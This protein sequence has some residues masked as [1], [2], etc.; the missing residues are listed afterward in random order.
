MADKTRNIRGELS[1]REIF[2]AVNDAILVH[3]AKT[4][5]IL[6]ANPAAEQLYGYSRAELLEMDIGEFSTNQPAYSQ[7]RAIEQ[8]DRAVQEGNNRFEWMIE[9]KDGTERT[10]DVKLTRETVQEGNLLLAVV[11]DVTERREA[12]RTTRQLREAVESSMDGVAVLDN[13]GE[14]VYVNGAHAE[15][16][17]FD[18]PDKLIGKSWR[19]MYTDEEI[20]RLEREAMSTIAA[21]GE[22]R[23]EATG[24]RVD[25]EHFPQEVSLTA[26]DSGGLICVVRDVT[27]R[28]EMTERVRKTRRELQ[29]V[30]DNTPAAVYKKDS[31]GRYQY[32]NGYYER[33]FDRPA[34]ELIGRLPVEIHGE[35]MAEMIT[36]H[37][38]YVIENGKATTTEETIEID[39]S[40]R[41]FLTSRIPLFDD[42][43]LDFLYGIAV[44]ITELKARERTLH[45]LNETATALVGARNRAEVAQLAV[46]T[47]EDAFSLPLAGVWEY[48][49]EAEALVPVAETD[50]SRD[51]VGEAPTFEEG[52]SLAWEAFKTSQP[53]F[54]EDVSGESDMFNPET[55][56]RSEMVLPL[57]EYGVLLCASTN[58]QTFDDYEREFGATLAAT[59]QTALTRIERERELRRREQV[60]H[61][62]TEVATSLI[63]AE[64]DEETA[65]IAVETAQDVLNLPLAGIWRHESDEDVLAPFVTSSGAEEIFDKLPTFKEGRGLSWR[66]FT[67]GRPEV[68]RD[69]TDEDEVYDPETPL[70]SEILLPLGEHG[71]FLCGT[72]ER[73]RFDEYALEFA[74]ILSTM[75]ESALTSADRERELRE[76]REFTDQL[77]STLPDLFYVFDTTSGTFVRWNDRLTEL[78]GYSDTEV[79]TTSVTEFVAEAD[80]ATLLDG[81]ESILNG[82]PTT[83]AIHIV[84]SDGRE[85][86]H[87]LTG[88]PVRDPDG[89]IIGVCGIGRDISDRLAY[90]RE[91][92]RKNAR[93][94]EFAS[95]VAHDIRNPLT[96]ATGY[97]ELAQEVG[98]GRY[99]EEVERG[100]ART[101]EI[102]E[103]LLT[104]AR[105]GEGIGER[106]SIELESLARKAW[107]NVR[108]SRAR[109]LIEDEVE[110]EGDRLRLTQLF[111]NLFRNAIEHAGEDVTIC[112][113]AL[114][115]GFY[116]EDNGSGIPEEHRAEL[117]VTRESDGKN[118]RFGLAI[119]SDIVEAHGWEIAVT[120]G[121]NGGA[122]FEIETQ[123]QVQL[124]TDPIESGRQR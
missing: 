5:T 43:E 54:V 85:V 96:V 111:E 29:A 39:G 93:L 115:E 120:N 23:G 66:V 81:L 19:A 99:L 50:H 97:L 84:A 109:L 82:E 26:L 36:A 76:Q 33:L 34:S 20:D 18:D 16:Y 73:R 77:I 98:D 123:S 17:G 92:E 114:T 90:E 94:E 8:I 100:L 79:E 9:R 63:D 69:V 60:L 86:P 112:F 12:E 53:R 2:H 101:A 51:I 38:Q 70:R 3:D 72:V 46:D 22:W 121:D 118:A 122:R 74:S 62:L 28:T 1:Y 71:V 108:T 55:S 106:E 27:E 25:G 110:V 52:T 83:I 58:A 78:T 91:L 104:L 21:E 61:S 89:E 56:I 4:G 24:H 65:E 37:D 44:D 119:V 105:A 10:V 117:F 80:E 95:V 64:T 42:G 48:D 31:E 32:V 41:S 15:M 103:N 35:E 49:A 124:E 59:V 67:S 107:E 47:A 13:V 30:L 57:G 102:T 75:T 88:A 45:A 14:Y 6:D 7:T 11:R 87:E 68:F 116:V 40:H 113:G